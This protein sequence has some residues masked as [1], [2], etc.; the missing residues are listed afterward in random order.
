M[1]IIFDLDGTLI[2]SAPD[3]RAVAS[4]MLRDRGREALA[5]IVAEAS[6]PAP[7]QG[8]PCTQM[9]RVRIPPGRYRAQ[10]RVILSR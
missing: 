10:C 1:N 3:I 5:D 4:A 2:D 7:K 8:C 6:S 9:G